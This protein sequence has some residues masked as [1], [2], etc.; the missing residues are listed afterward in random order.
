MLRSRKACSAGLMVSAVLFCSAT[1]S[2][3][4]EVYDN[5]AVRGTYAYTVGYEYPY[6][7]SDSFT[8][9]HTTSLTEAQVGLWS[10]S[11]APISLDWSIGTTAFGNDISSSAPEA[12]VSS[13]Y[14]FNNSYEVFDSVFP[15][16]GALVAGQTYWLTIF[17]AEASTPSSTIFWDASYGPSTAIQG[18]FNLGGG[19]T[20][21][22]SESFQL[23]GNVV[24]TPEPATLMLLG[25]G[26]VLLSGVGLR[27]ARKVG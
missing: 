12:S 15:V 7:V 20:D 3:A 1:W 21:I 13:T 8:V 9:S 24:S 2:Q 17:A 5:G 6:H 22:S 4:S 10:Q 25:T 19:Q 18:T 26:L 27:K 16:S 11:G 14:L 23:Y